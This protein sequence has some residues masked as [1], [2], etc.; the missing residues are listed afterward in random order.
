MLTGAHDRHRHRI[1][2]GVLDRL[3]VNDD[4]HAR[5]TV[6]NRRFTARVFCESIRQAACETTPMDP[7]GVRIALV[8]GAGSGVG[9]A[10]AIGLAE[11]GFA[12][13]LAG[14]RARCPRGNG[15]RGHRRLVGAADRRDRCCQCR[16][17]LRCGRPA[18]RPARPAVQQRRCRCPASAARR[19]DARRNGS[20]LSTPTSPARSCARNGRWH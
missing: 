18:V 19:A 13:V 11:D 10:V 20:V 12:V 17:P 16:C 7:R 9:R 3:V 2:V 5:P 6:A 8:T 15:G 14:R 1:T 4:A